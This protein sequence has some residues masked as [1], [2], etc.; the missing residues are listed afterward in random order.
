M[1][2]IKNWTFCICITLIIS[3]IFMILSPKGSMGKFYKIIISIFIFISFLYPLTDFNFNRHN[4]GPKFESEY[5]DVVEN[6]VDI[7]IKNSIKNTLNDNGIKAA[8]IYVETTLKKDEVTINKVVISI[9]D[10]YSKDEVK[11]ILFDK[12]GIVAD[13]KYIGE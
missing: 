6:S 10:E 9:I 12:L 1:D 4:V 8:D 11:N 7:E 2:F 3:V 13:V 5:S